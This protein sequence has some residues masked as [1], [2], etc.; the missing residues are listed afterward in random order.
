LNHGDYVLIGFDMKKDANILNKAYNDSENVTAEFNLN[1]LR[2][3]NRELGGNFDLDQF[4]FNSFYNEFS[5]AVESYLISQK[6]QVVNI[7]SLNK[8]FFFKKSEP[9]HTENSFKFDEYEI[10]ELAKESGFDQVRSFSDSKCYFM[11]S[12]WRVNKE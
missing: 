12:L 8:S 11:D 4:E 7:G 1:L 9:I 2:R 5:G 3:I 10:I 6:D